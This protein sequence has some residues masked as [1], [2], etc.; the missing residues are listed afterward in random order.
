ML[1]KASLK[2]NGYVYHAITV[3]IFLLCWESLRQC[4]S[5]CDVN[6]RCRCH[7]IDYNTTETFEGITI[8]SEYT[9]I[10]H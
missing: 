7:G 2:R 10:R 8:L 6:I 9:G 3:V 4:V 1:K 5:K